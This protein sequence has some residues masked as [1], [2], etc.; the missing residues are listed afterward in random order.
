MA[1][2]YQSN[3]QKQGTFL[4]H[5]RPRLIFHLGHIRMLNALYEIINE[6]HNVIILIIPY[7]E[8]DRNNQTIKNRLNE[9]I[10]ITKGF[11]RDY[12]RFSEPQL[13]I[14]S[15]YDLEISQQKI[16]DINKLYSELYKTSSNIKKLIDERNR[17]WASPN[18]TFVAKCISAI[19]ILKPDYLICGAKHEWISDCFDEILNAD[20][21]NV[22]SF[23]FEDFKDLFLKEAM[24]GTDSIYSLVEINDNYDLIQQKLFLVKDIDTKNRWLTHFIEKIFVSAPERIKS[25]IGQVQRNN[26][27]QENALNKFLANVRFLIPYSMDNDVP[28]KEI[29]VE[30]ADSVINIISD[31]HKIRIE[32]IIRAIYKKREYTSVIVQRIFTSGRSGSFVFEIREY[33]SEQTD[34]ISNVSILKIGNYEDLILEFN[35][36]NELVKNRKTYAFME[37]SDKSISIENYVG[38]LY[39][40]AHHHLAIKR[41]ER[42]YTIRKI[43]Q[44]NPIPIDEIKEKIGTLF[45]SHLNE[46]LYK[47]GNKVDIGSIKKYYNEFLPSEFKV[48]V[49]YYDKDDDTLKRNNDEGKYSGFAHEIILT[50]VNLRDKNVRAYSTDSSHTKIDL[51][52]ND[53]EMLLNNLRKDR[54]IKINGII[55]ATRTD[56][57]NETLVKINVKKNG[58]I[59]ELNDDVQIPDI[60]SK[61]DEVLALEHHDFQLSPV[62]GDLHCENVLYGEQNFGII[63]YGKMRNRC[64]SI[65]D[66][67][68]LY[69]D[70]KLKELTKQLKLKQI[71]EIEEI[72]FKGRILWWH[73][74]T[75][76]NVQIFSTF[77]YNNL[78]V[79][80]KNKGSRNLFYSAL[81]LTYLGMLKF[82]LDSDVKKAALILAYFSYMKIK[83]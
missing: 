7:D 55:R 23:Y 3:V 54:V 67:A 66:I 22:K 73:N 80:I 47:H 42:I 36:Y 41:Q 5:C 52:F 60:I 13:N 37:I 11:Y 12:L 31:Y 70:I 48:E 62:H 14:V 27:E 40:D 49:D 6:G 75:T 4:L 64:V 46:T 10:L 33:E 77:E 26:A 51:I 9:E 65:Y 25:N 28:A 45:N 58:K 19:E 79:E 68:Y 63:D 16:N 32:K 50:E 61:I 53:D 78:P 38:I 24:D 20:R 15:T 30:W 35:N 43:F 29:K 83:L 2:K 71:Y 18:I 74:L 59:L 56:Y 76:P 72:I 17:K 82:D 44:R 39:Q 81:M 34:I 8:H 57:F 21:F 69:A 1:L